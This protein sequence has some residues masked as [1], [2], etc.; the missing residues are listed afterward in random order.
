M[1]NNILSFIPLEERIVLDAAAAAVIYVNVHATGAV[2]DGTSWAHAYTDLQSALAKAASTPGPDQI[3]IA[4]GTYTPGPSQTDTFTLPNNVALYG[5]FAGNEH[6][7]A[8]RKVNANPTILS[9]DLLGNDLAGNPYTATSPAF[10]ASIADNTNTIITAN[11]VTALLDGLTVSGANN[12]GGNGGGILASNDN[13]T[14]NNMNIIN[15]TAGGGG[16]IYI[17]GSILSVSNSIFTN[18][19]AGGGGGISLTS[20][21]QTL[22]NVQFNQDISLGGGGAFGAL[23]SSS[24]VTNSSF[25][26]CASTQGDSG[27]MYELSVSPGIY[28]TT[29]SNCKFLNNYSN[30]GIGAG[31]IDAI[32]FGAG[33]TNNL[34]F[35]HCDF[36]GNRTGIGLSFPVYGGAINYGLLV[37]GSITNS[38]FENNTSTN[39]GAISIARPTF[40]TFPSAGSA[41]VTISNTSFIN[42]TATDGGG[43]IYNLNAIALTLNHDLFMG[44]SA[45][46]HGGAI[47]TTNVN[48]VTPI[49]FAGGTFNVSNSAFVNNTAADGGAIYFQY[50]QTAGSTPI[51]TTVSK[52]IFS[53]NTASIGSD[54]SQS[55][56]ISTVT[57]NLFLE[58]DSSGGLVAI[59]AGVSTVNNQTSASAIINSLDNSNILLDSD[60]IYIF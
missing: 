51:Q 59:D 10:L 38:S 8:Q 42:N 30:G 15:D 43:A 23:D 39:G 31:V 28:L 13:L 5:G 24:T 25:V 52:N 45:G 46:N 4:K 6:T 11:G 58:P 32:N 22:T 57:G 20:T 29:F 36:N 18:D 41:P 60:D 3:W 1:N 37:G 19:S 54:F 50:Q 7:V 27:A 44:N 34:N 14:L 48:V 56:G 26:G 47:E 55:G 33:A 16:G 2:H 21:T 53:G 35:D 49:P 9:G 12:S 17:T 40:V